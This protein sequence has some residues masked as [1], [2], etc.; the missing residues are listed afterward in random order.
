[1]LLARL[2]PLVLC[3]ALAVAA[4]P[5]AAQRAVSGD[6]Q[7][8]MS[9]QQFKAAGLDKLSPQELTAL[10]DWLQGKVAKETAVALEKAKEEGRQEVIVKNRGFFDFGSQ[11]PIESTLVGTF[12]GFSK[13][14]R[15]VL[16]NG[17]EW[18]QTEAASL[19]SV[20]RTA[21]K[22]KITPGIMGA[23]YMQIDTYNT[24]AKVRRIK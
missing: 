24:R 1:M 21:P 18:E 9:A 19:A 4:A 12:S 17:Q 23:W 20:R 14:R 6:L 16:A 7:A 13:G 8:Q 10:N 11:E 22:V 2:I 3:A 5:A 15:Y